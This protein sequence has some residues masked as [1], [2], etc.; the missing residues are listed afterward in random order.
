MMDASMKSEDWRATSNSNVEQAETGMWR[1]G[2]EDNSALIH[3]TLTLS[4]ATFNI[5]IFSAAT[6]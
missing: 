2:G 1:L 6:I 4:R 3:G 5:R